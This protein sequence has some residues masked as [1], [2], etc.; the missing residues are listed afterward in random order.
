[1]W[2]RWDMQETPPDILIT[3]YVMLNI[4]MMRSIENDIFEKTRE[5]LAEPGHPERQF[6][7]IIDELHAYR[8][9][10]GTE[11]AYILRLL[12]H[13]LGLEPD[14]DKLRILTTTASLEPNIEGRTFLHQFFGRDNFSFISGTETTPRRVFL[15][16]YQPAFEDFARSV[17]PDSTRGDGPPDSASDNARAAMRDLAMKL[18]SSASSGSS[19][20]M[21]GKALQQIGAPDA[22]RAASKSL[23]S[24]DAVRPTLLPRLDKYLF[25]NSSSQTTKNESS[26]ALRGLLLALAMSV[27]DSGG[28]APQ[29]MRGHIFFHHMLNLWVC[30]NPN[31]DKHS[32]NQDGRLQEPESRRP[33]VGALHGINR[34]T[35][36]CGS[37]VLDLI[38]C[39]V[40][41]DVFLGGY[42]RIENGH[43]Y[44]TPDQPDLENM[45]DR[46]NL[47]QRHGQYALFWPLPHDVSPWTTQP[48]QTEWRVDGLKR[49]WV[50]AK[51]HTG[52]GLVMQD[53]SPLRT[54]EVPGW[55]Y[56]VPG[57]NGDETAPLPTRCPRCDADYRH[58]KVFRSPL[59]NHRTGFQKACQVLASA[60]LREMEPS[61]DKVSTQTKK[62]VIFS[63]SRQDAAKLAAG[64]ERDH[65]RDMVRFVMIDALRDYWRDLVGFLRVTLSFNPL[66]LPALESLNPKLHE[67]VDSQPEPDDMAARARFVAANPS[68]LTLEAQN[69]MMQVPPTDAS[70]HDRWIEILQAYPGRIPLGNLQGKIYSKLLE[71]GLCPGGSDSS[72]KSYWVNRQREQWYNCYNWQASP[73][74]RIT[75]ASSAQSEHIRRMQ[76]S[77]MGEL[78]YA[79]FPHVARTLEGLGQGWVSYKPTDGASQALTDITE[80]VIRQLGT[81]RRHEYSRWVD[82][83]TDERL[84]RYCSNYINPLGFT[85]SD[86]VQQLKQSAGGKPSA[87]G[88]VLSPDNLYIVPE[89]NAPGEQIEGYRCP[90]CRAFYLHDVQHCTECQQPTRVEPDVAS[91]VFDYYTELTR[92]GSNPFRMNCEELTGQTDS[93]DRPK[94]QRWFQEIFIN[95]EIPQ[96][97]GVDL[98]SVTTT[99]E[100]GVD[101]GSLNATMMANMPPRRFNYQQRVGRAGRRASGISLAVTFCRGRSHDDFYYQRPESMTGDPP[102]SPYVDMNS[103]PILKRVLV[104]EVLRL[105]FFAIDVAEEENVDNVH[106]DFGRASAWSTFEPVIKDWLANPRN[107][108]TIESAIDLLTIGT[109]WSGGDGVDFR[110]NMLNYLQNQM[111]ED[112]RQ[113]AEDDS[114]AQGALSERLANAGLLPMFGFPTRVRLLYTYWPRRSSWPPSGVVDRDLDIAISQFAPG[115]QT[116]KDKQVHTAIGIVDL[117]PAGNM[118]QS[119]NGFAPPLPD[120]NPHPI[121]LCRTCQAVVQYHNQPLIVQGESPVEICPVCNDQEPSLFMLDSREPNGFFTDL[122]PEDFEGQF[123][124]QPRSTRP[125]LSFDVRGGTATRVSNC[126][127]HALNSEILS[128]NDN[129][130]DGGF[131]FK[132]VRVDGEIKD[133]AFAVAADELSDNA[134]VYRKVSTFGSS[135]RVAL[136]SKRKTDVLLVNIDEWPQ[137]LFAD[138]LTVEGRAAWFSFAFWLRSAAGAH[139]DVDPLELRSGYRST[140]GSLVGSSSPVIGQA[141]LSDHLENGAGYCVKLGE[142]QQ[143]Q[144]LLLQGDVNSTNS[145]AE[146]WTSAAAASGP[147]TSHATE[148]DTSCNLCLRDFSNQPYHGLLDWRLALDMARIALSPA[149]TIDLQTQWEGQPNPWQPLV[150]SDQASIPALMKQLG[151]ESSETFETLRGYIH[152]TKNKITIERHPLWQEDHTEW[153]AARS[154]AMSRYASFEV[155]AMNPFRALRRPAEYI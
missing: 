45:P 74:Q 80:A 50:R 91:D 22:I 83:G 43:V 115:S 46:V 119:S 26:V 113:I 49:Q 19:E 138:P 96:V 51:L 62:L 28:R 63:D 23:A 61:V 133:G 59:R 31:C 85:D 137:G 93:D 150:A 143:F 108:Q 73:P 111:I 127:V 13:R 69:W 104:K 77:L 134:N 148:C 60:L 123:E 107:Q 6:F 131:N 149:N 9:T 47:G 90:Q 109:P 48:Q 66:A 106:G 155:Y 72:I 103:V 130:G 122:T 145:I 95:E 68:E 1:M 120:P 121:G 78:M 18:G 144:D 152:P 136:L 105:A 32:V 7:L 89:I 147:H 38:V 75:G 2:S 27:V 70:A 35:C 99:M 128:I 8:G 16:P 94:R 76:D 140:S 101:I 5:W 39:E 34:M 112:V 42:K 142:P 54:S 116:V 11:V 125:S 40:C 132:S 98:L 81:H 71:M 79:L 100:A 10:P 84:G 12:L 146:K 124:W 52:M 67:I 92:P 21:L 25:P 44:L 153:I 41:G 82:P 37:R 14:S 65:Y 36:G 24:N 139:L 33:T 151:Y 97:H 55:L 87:M 17:Q 30:C 56:H 129:G 117:W 86:V 102:P 4:M 29:P 118:V 88:M 57:K 15:K 135:W 110:L 20:E 126:S 141:F 58:R 114:Y 64:M 53:S 154:A 3:N